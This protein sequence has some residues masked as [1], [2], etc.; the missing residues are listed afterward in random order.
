[1]TRWQPLQ[2]YHRYF[3]RNSPAAF[4]FNL[5]LSDKFWLEYGEPILRMDFDRFWYFGE[6]YRRTRDSLKLNQ[7]LSPDRGM[8]RV[9]AR[10]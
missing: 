3:A 1:M 7:F 2:A 9:F 10:W 8:L 5:P 4:S 6:G